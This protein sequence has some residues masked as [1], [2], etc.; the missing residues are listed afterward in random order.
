[1][2]I[3]FLV[4]GL[5]IGASLPVTRETTRSTLPSTAAVGYSKQIEPIA[6]A[7]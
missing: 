2:P 1:M 6:P 7:V 3:F 4:S 5:S